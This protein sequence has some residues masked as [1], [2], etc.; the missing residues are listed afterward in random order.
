MKKDKLYISMELGKWLFFAIVPL[1]FFIMKCVSISNVDGGTKFIIS[2]S[3]YIFLLLIFIVVKKAMLKNYIAD[4]NGKIVNYTTQLETEVDE[5]KIPLIEKAMGKA[6]IYRHSI[7]VVPIIA[8]SGLILVVVKAL[9]DSLVKLYS[10]VGI[11][12]VS[13]IFGFICMLVQSKNVRSK[14]RRN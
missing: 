6:L 12:L 1:V 10:V 7:N 9:E 4:L 3:S 5:N 13:F 14:N 11:C 8:V 2:A